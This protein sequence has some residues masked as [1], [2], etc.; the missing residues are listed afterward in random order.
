VGRSAG[1]GAFYW[2][3]INVGES[4]LTVGGASPGRLVLG[5]VRKQAEQ[6]HG[7]Q[8]SEQHASIVFASIPAFGFL[9]DAP[10]TLRSKK[11]KKDF[12]SQAECF[13][14]Q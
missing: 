14:Q 9:S 10:L 12:P 5:S 13:L 6:S 8:A 11:K 7:E 4:Q 2:L 3:V 1:E